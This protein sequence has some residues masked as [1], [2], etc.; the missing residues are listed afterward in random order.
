MNE[1]NDLKKKKIPEIVICK[2]YIAFL[3]KK[4]IKVII[5]KHINYLI[6]LLGIEI[7]D[8]KKLID[9]SYGN[10]FLLAKN[11]MVSW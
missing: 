5:S 11:F 7:N 10:I 6:R 2:V 8:K 1:Q 3:K 9:K 4:K